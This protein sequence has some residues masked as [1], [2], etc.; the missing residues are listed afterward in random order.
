MAT[1]LSD[2]WYV[3]RRPDDPSLVPAYLHTEALADLNII[4]IIDDGF[5]NAL[6]WCSAEGWTIEPSLQ[7]T[8]WGIDEG[9]FNLGGPPEGTVDPVVVRTPSTA[10]VRLRIF[11][12]GLDAR[13]AERRDLLLM[14]LGLD[15]SM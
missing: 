14:A 11:K 10:N 12:G 9:P 3:L 13:S 4:V 5:G 7:D 8:Q 1:P 2:A 15:P 6:A